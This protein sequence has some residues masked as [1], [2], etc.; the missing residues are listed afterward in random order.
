M[1]DAPDSFQYN[2]AVERGILSDM[3]ELAARLGSPN[4]FTR[5]GVTIFQDN[6]SNGLDEWFVSSNPPIGQSIISLENGGHNGVSCHLDIGDNPNN[7]AILYRYFAVPELAKTGIELAVEFPQYFDTFDFYLYLY[8]AAGQAIGWIRYD[9]ASQS[10]Q[11][12]DENSA[13]VS[14]ATL[15]IQQANYHRYDQMKLIVDFEDFTYHSFRYN[16]FHYSLAD[17]P[18]KTVSGSGGNSLLAYVKGVSDGSNEADFYIS[19][20]ILTT[21]EI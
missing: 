16:Q 1:A 6:F 11:Y 14:F 21:D 17:L 3:A 10:F 12:Y 9:L 13:F 15:D 19:Y 20:L 18:L 7:S 4:T 8:H 5:T 2:K